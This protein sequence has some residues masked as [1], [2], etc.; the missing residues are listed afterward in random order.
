MKIGELA[1]QCGCDVET[2]RYY[3]RAGVLDAPK[4]APN[5]YRAYGV[6]HLTQLKF[7]RHCR[8]LG[9]GLAEVKLLQ[10]F[11]K[12][13]AQP[14]GKVDRLID[15][16]I[17]TIH[18]QIQNLHALEQQLRALRAACD[19]KSPIAECGIMRSL[20]DAAIGED[21]PCHLVESGD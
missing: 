20:S 19:E 9:M 21:C 8:S 3:E 17:A 18:Q 10:S 5:G 13:P 12:N 1:A 2:V 15:E 16:H 11:E 14:C 7:V 4:R 6:A